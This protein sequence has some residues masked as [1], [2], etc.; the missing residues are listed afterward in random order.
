[1]TQKA[2]ARGK[3]NSNSLAAD[4]DVNTEIQ[5]A[6]TFPPSVRALNKNKIKDGFE[7]STERK[8][9]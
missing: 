1:M 7:A 9:Q 2:P 6:K 4:S 5:T 8:E 3:H